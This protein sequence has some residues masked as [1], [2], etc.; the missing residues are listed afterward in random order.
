MQVCY[1]LTLIFIITNG[2]TTGMLSRPTLVMSCR[3]PGF[4]LKTTDVAYAIALGSVTSS[5][6]TRNI[7]FIYFIWIK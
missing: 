2:A 6:P 1:I 3:H 7:F 4:A 5:F